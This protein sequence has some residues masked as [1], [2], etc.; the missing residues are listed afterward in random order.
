M[1]IACLSIMRFSSSVLGTFL[2]RK[3]SPGLKH[4]KKYVR[5]V[6]GAYSPCE[7]RPIACLLILN[8]CFEFSS[9][10]LARKFLSKRKK[11]QVMSETIIGPIC[12]LGEGERTDQLYP[13]SKLLSIVS[14][15]SVSYVRSLQHRMYKVQGC[16]LF[17]SLAAIAPVTSTTKPLFVQMVNRIQ[18]Q[19]F[20]YQ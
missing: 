12:S 18:R 4:K 2:V 16:R 20:F 8:S 15:T 19:F 7:V 6:Y 10:F 13:G 9:H 3:F 11:S 14:G 17:W 5:N 1:S